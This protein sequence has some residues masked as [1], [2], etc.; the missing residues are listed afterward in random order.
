MC[1]CVYNQLLSWLPGKV[2]LRNMHYQGIICRKN[3]EGDIVI[4]FILQHMN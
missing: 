3:L 2:Y 1:E 4:L